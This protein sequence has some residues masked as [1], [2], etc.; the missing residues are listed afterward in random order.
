MTTE[1]EN[2]DNDI[3]MEW[4]ISQT[5]VTFTMSASHRNAVDSYIDANLDILKK[6]DHAKILYTIQDISSPDVALTPYLKERLNEITDY[7]KSNQ[8]QVR[9]GVVLSNNLT[10]QLMQ[11]FGRIF[12][13][14]AKYLK[15]VYFTDIKSAQ[16]WIDR[17]QTN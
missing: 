2:L 6:W 15:Q 9:T 12:T 11:I 3:T 10:G 16:D 1:I 13:I 5:Q 8:I 4:N 14:N 17:Q 7:I